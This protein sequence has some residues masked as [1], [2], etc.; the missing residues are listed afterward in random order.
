MSGRSLANEDCGAGGKREDEYSSALC[1][2]TIGE[3][4]AFPKCEEE[5]NRQDGHSHD[6]NSKSL[7][8]EL[9]AEVDANELW[10]EALDSAL[11]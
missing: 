8:P 11:R 6:E 5:S 3:L 7:C 2:T 10:S 4:N 1:V 9:T